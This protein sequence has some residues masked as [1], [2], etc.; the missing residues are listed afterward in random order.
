MMEEKLNSVKQDTIIIDDRNS[1]LSTQ[2]VQL[3]NQ[4]Q[5]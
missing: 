5:E 3:E 1:A 2:A 4:K